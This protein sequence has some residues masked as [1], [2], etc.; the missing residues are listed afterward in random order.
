MANESQ[1]TEFL[2]QYMADQQKAEADRQLQ[3]QAMESLQKSIEALK[4]VESRVENL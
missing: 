3:W 2:K 4:P 1:F